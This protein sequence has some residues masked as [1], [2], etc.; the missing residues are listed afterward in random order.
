MA[1]P[2]TPTIT[3][4]E[5]LQVDIRRDLTIICSEYNHPASVEM[6]SLIVHV[7]KDAGFSDIVWYGYTESGNSLQI[8]SAYGTFYSDLAGKSRLDRFQWYYIRAKYTDIDGGQSNWS[9]VIN[10]GTGEKGC[11]LY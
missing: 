8:S 7:A 2:D 4:P 9:T 5:N 10:F 1:V 3:H 11:P 6:D